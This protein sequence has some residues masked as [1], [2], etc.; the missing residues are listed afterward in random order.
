MAQIK[1]YDT[2]SDVKDHIQKG[3]ILS[4][5]AELTIH[6][7]TEDI[8]VTDSY[9]IVTSASSSDDLKT[10]NGGTQAGQILVLQAATGK[11]LTVHKNDGN[12]KMASDITLDAVTESLTLIYNGANWNMLSSGA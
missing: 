3:R 11:T 7:T 9:H 6:A 12:I 8:T 5:G 2:L 4:K 10:I 1:S